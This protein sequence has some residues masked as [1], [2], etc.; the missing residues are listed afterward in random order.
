[1]KW[2]ANKRQKVKSFQRGRF[3]FLMMR[4]VTDDGVFAI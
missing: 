2:M 4:K 1:M 3:I